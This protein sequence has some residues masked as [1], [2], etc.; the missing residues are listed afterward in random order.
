VLLTKQA[1]QAISCIHA[2]PWIQGDEL[3]THPKGNTARYLPGKQSAIVA[4]HDMQYFYQDLLFLA[5]TNR[6]SAFLSLK[7]FR[8]E[9]QGM[10]NRNWKPG[11]PVPIIIP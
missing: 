3:L 8:P 10:A 11:I 7:I 1:R 4:L 6:F 5:K 9:I 2:R